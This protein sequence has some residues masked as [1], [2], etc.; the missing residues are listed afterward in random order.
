MIPTVPQV[1]AGNRGNALVN[2][3]PVVV[4][5]VP[6]TRYEY[7]GGGV[8]ILQLAVADAAGQPFAQLVK[9]HAW[10]P[11]DMSAS[12]FCQP[13][14]VDLHANAARAYEW[15]DRPEDHRGSAEAKWHVY[16]ELYAA[17]LWT[18]PSDLAKFLI[19]VQLS[20]Q[21]ALQQGPSSEDHPEDGDAGWHRPL[22]A[23]IHR[24]IDLPARART[25]RRSSSVVRA[26]PAETGGSETILSD[27]SK[28]GPAL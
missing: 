15:Q 27:I 3:L 23:G 6:N 1:L 9:D 8:T 20:L 28:M 11:I 19:E 7:S 24:R 17:G 26:I 2:T 12:C 25:G 13:L 14:P 18:T 10:T 21:G 16:P 5:W 22:R 4:N